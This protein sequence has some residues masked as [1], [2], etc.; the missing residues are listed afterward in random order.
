MKKLNGVCMALAA[1]GLFSAGTA[2]ASLTAFQTYVGKVG[3]STD[4]FGSTA[5]TGTISASVPVG[6]TVLAAYLYTSTFNSFSGVNGTTFNGNAVSFSSL[7]TNT[8]ACCSLTAGRTDVTSIVKAI[9]D[10]GAGGVYDFSIVESSGNQDGE[11]LVVVYSN[12]TLGTSTV[13]ILDGFA[14]VTGDTTSINFNAPLHPA[15]LGFSAEM[16]LGIGFSFD[17]SNCI[18]NG[19]VSKVTV[20]GTLITN[21]AGCNDDSVN[22]ASNGNLI[23]V[24]GYDDPF[25][26]LLPAT[27]NDHERCNLV[28]YITDGATTIKIDNSNASLNDNI[29]LAVVKVTGEGGVNKPP[30]PPS[31][32]PEPG[33]LALAGLALAGLGGLRRKSKRA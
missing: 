1:A 2:Q 27:E 6:S 9:I 19:Q 13:G 24:G 3:Y 16:A 20:N 17:G 21:N 29:F 7:G 15:A 26:A 28:P 14:N 12:P 5:Q 11:A 4:G 31:D 22:G 32:L 8:D 23:T 25:S 18:G 30:P 33:S 10:G